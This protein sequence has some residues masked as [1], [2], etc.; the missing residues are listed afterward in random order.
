[1]A[2]DWGTAANDLIQGYEANQQAKTAQAQAD[3]QVRIAQAKA[4]AASS[5]QANINSGGGM[6]ASSA[7]PAVNQ[8]SVF[9]DQLSHMGGSINWTY[10]GLGFVALLGIALAMKMV[11]A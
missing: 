9:R 8:N 5:N 7:G 1:M 3:A 6:A 4:S 11:K 2:I 10:V